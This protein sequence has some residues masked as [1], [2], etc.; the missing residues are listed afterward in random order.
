MRS[1]NAITILALLMLSCIAIAQKNTDDKEM[2]RFVDNL[3]SKMTLEEKIGQL[4]LLQGE[5]DYSGD[6]HRYASVEAVKNGMVGG[7]LNVEGVKNVIAMQRIAVEETR[8]HIPMI[9]GLDVI[10]GF[11]TVYPI[12]LGLSCTWDLAAIER[13]ARIAALEAT[14]DGLCWTYSPMVDICH[15]ARWGRIAEGSGEDPYLGCRIAEALVRG[16]QGN[17]LKADN[18]MMACVKHFA[19]YG[20]AEAGRDYNTADMSRWRMYNEYLPPYKAAIDAGAGSVM[21]SFN[22]V[23]GVPAT[24][25]KW[26]LTD[27]LR[28]EWGFKGFVVSDFNSINEMI[29]HGIGGKKEVCALALNAGLDMDMCAESYQDHLLQNVKEGKVS[30]KAIDEACRRILEAKYKLGLFDDP[31]RYCDTTRGS[32]LILCAEHR[33]DARKTA[34]ESLVLLKNQ[35]NILPLKCQGK[36]ALIGPMA[37]NR[38]NMTGTW[39][40]SA[41]PSRYAT[42]LEGMRKAMGD[43]G[44]ILYA[45]GSNLMYDAEKEAIATRSKK[46]RDARSDKQMLDEAIAVARQ[47]DVIVLAVGECAEMSGEGSSRVNI[48]LPDAQRDLIR[49]IAKIGKPMVMLNFSGRPVILN[50][51]N[52]NIDAIVQCWFAGSETS[53]AIPDVLFGNVTPSGKLTTTF[54]RHVGQYPMYYAHYNTGRPMGKTFRRYRSNYLDVENDGLYPFGYGLSYT[55]F[56]YSKMELSDTVMSKDGKIT[57]SVTVK[58]TG[59]YDGSEIVQLYI[60]DVYGSVVRPNKELKGFERIDLKKG[61]SKRV[62]FVIDEEMLKFYNGECKLV[63]EPGEFRVMIG[64]NSRDLEERHFT[65]Q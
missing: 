34:A 32:K 2:K 49:E 24:G 13:S 46:M 40:W 44:E 52:D 18:T 30:Q 59:N 64:A 6:L 23:D 12:P 31:Y 11:S 54:P 41:Q 47:A 26:L 25:N 36:I 8:L 33:A 65:L 38:L 45:K 57:A 53:D 55:T 56:E 15:D 9:F 51:E 39:S 22:I 3:M 16:Y 60:R 42:L 1:R 43:N 63:S 4:N 20:D 10:H 28:K 17:D 27:L 35:D 58:N 14:A 50:W 61:E 5:E 19:I 29:A 48:E 62:E 37:D 21:S 7:M